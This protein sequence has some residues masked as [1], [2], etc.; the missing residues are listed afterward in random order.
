M[1]NIMAP[2]VSSFAARAVRDHACSPYAA[3]P[4]GRGPR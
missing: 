4:P 2:L 3:P 1:H